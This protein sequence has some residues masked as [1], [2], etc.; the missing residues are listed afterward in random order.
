MALIDRLQNIIAPL[1]D[2]LAVELVDLEYAGGVVRVVVDRP[3]GVDMEAIA[4]LTREISRAFDHDDPINGRYTLEVSSPGLERT[5]R[6]PA[7]FTRALGANV[8]IKTRPGCEGD[9]RIEGVLAA[10]D[11]HG[12]VVRLSAPADAERRL[13][14]DDIERA[15]TVF[16]WGPGPKPGQAS[17]DAATRKNA[18]KQGA[19]ATRTDAEKRAVNA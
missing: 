2:D 17:K 5:L 3:G 12:V 8:R 19:A 11:D 14:Y 6:T 18:A 1:C 9:R 13:G 4:R 7:H 16:E 15:R 10:A